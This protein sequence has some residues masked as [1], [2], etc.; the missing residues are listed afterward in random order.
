MTVKVTGR[1]P[2]TRRAQVVGRD[3]KVLV[4][5]ENSEVLRSCSHCRSRGRRLRP[6]RDVG[7]SVAWTRTGLDD[8]PLL[9][10]WLDGA[11][12]ARRRR[13]PA[14]HDPRA[15]ARR[16]DLIG[17]VVAPATCRCTARLA[18]VRDARRAVR[19][20]EA[21]TQ[22]GSGP[23]GAGTPSAAPPTA[24]RRSLLAVGRPGDT[25]IVDR[26]SHRSVLLGLVLAGLRPV[27]V[28]PP[29]HAGTGLPLGLGAPTV[30]DALRA[31][32]DAC[33]VLR[34]QPVVRRD[35]R[36]RRSDRR[37]DPCGRR[38]AASSTRRGVRTW[39]AIPTCRRTRSR[40]AR[41]PSSPAPTRPCPR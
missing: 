8:A 9:R 31:H 26:T 5:V 3:A 36:G 41:T 11:A 20:A 4:T 2:A 7:A 23:T 35:L 38:S 32:P 24:T 29:I 13:A 21:R 12:A 33:A 14:V 34:H 37:G 22:S 27:W 40:P 1:S 15:Q 17:E 18:A 30:A 28:H 10:A 25:V 19:R 16:S 6:D 39:A